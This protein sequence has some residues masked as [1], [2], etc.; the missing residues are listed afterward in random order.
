MKER[1]AHEQ[2]SYFQHPAGHRFSFIVGL[3]IVSAISRSST[4]AGT[5]STLDCV[6]MK[7]VVRADAARPI[8]SPSCPSE[9]RIEESARVARKK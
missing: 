8:K 2:R 3:A 6:G 4:S 5:E 9:T 1:M 7:A